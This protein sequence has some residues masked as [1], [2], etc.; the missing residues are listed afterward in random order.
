MIET[1]I[2]AKKVKERWAICKVPSKDAVEVLDTFIERDKCYNRFLA[3]RK[4]LPKE[5]I[6][7]LSMLPLDEYG[8]YLLPL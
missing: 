7:E 2:M 8:N 1:T 5:R 3:M 4:E 6:D